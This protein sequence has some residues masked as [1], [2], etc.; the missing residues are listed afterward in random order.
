MASELEG[1][2]DHLECTPGDQ[3]RLSMATT[4]AQITALAAELGFT[5]TVQ[6]LRQVSRELCAPWWPWSEKG[7]AWRRSFFRR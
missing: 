1:F 3:Q 2:V 4:P 5:V 6:E 7:N